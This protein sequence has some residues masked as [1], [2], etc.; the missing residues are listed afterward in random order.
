[1]LT[2]TI[3]FILTLNKKNKNNPN[4]N[5]IN[6]ILFPEKSIPALKIQITIAGAINLKKL[7]FLNV[8]IV[9]SIAKNENLCI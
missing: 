1:M 8:R 3:F 2:N 7:L 4:T 9:K 6:G 5:K